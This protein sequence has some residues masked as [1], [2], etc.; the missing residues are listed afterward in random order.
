MA[1]DAAAPGGELSKFMT[2][3]PVGQ[4]ENHTAAGDY[5]GGIQ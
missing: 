5:H 2:D 3:S 1:I 4:I